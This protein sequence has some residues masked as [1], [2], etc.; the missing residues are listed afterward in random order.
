M[1][2]FVAVVAMKSPGIVEVDS[3]FDKPQTQDAAIEFEIARRLP[4][5]GGHMMD[6][7]HGM[8]FVVYG[9]TLVGVAVG[10]TLEALYGC[11]DPGRN[12]VRDLGCASCVKLL[13]RIL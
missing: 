13:H 10:C 4:G 9:I 11:R 2:D 8:T 1:P 5:N 7:G 6:T 12:K 3:L